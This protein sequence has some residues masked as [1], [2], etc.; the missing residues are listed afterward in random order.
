MK[1]VIISALAVLS[2]PLTT[3]NAYAKMKPMSVADMAAVVGHS[4]PQKDQAYDCGT[5]CQEV[6]PP[7]MPS[8]DHSTMVVGYGIIVC[9]APPPDDGCAPVPPDRV[10]GKR[11][12]YKSYCG[13]TDVFDKWGH[14]QFAPAKTGETI[15]PG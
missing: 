9:G 5:A 7:G 2:L 12:F 6:W 4:V 3:G 8:G 13:T 15:C 11:A 14:C 1:Y 10:C